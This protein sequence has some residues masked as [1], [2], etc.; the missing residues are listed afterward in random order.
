VELPG[1]FCLAGTGGDVRVCVQT[2][3]YHTYLA[4][5][6]QLYIWLDNKKPAEAGFWSNI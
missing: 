5:K 6:R 3:S 2:G 1:V 4:F